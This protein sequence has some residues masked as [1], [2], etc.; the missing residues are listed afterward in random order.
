MSAPIRHP[1]CARALAALA[2]V[3]LAVVVALAALPARAR[4]ADSEPTMLM[5]DQQLI[6]DG[7]SHAI[8]VLHQLHSLG[9]DTVKV[10]LV[11]SLIAP[12]PNSRRA[13]HFDA[14]S[15]SAYPYGAWDRW[16]LIDNVA[17]QLGMS[18]SFQIIGPAPVWARGTSVANQGKTLGRFPNQVDLRQFVE[19]AG[20]RYSGSYVPNPSAA[21]ASGG[22]LVPVPIPTT[23]GASIAHVRQAAPYTGYTLPAGQA[24][25]RVSRWEIWNEPDE[26]DWLNPWFA[27]RGASTIYIEAGGY[28]RIVSAA[29]TGLH[30]TGHGSD[31]ILIGETANVGVRGPAYFTRALYCVGADDRPLRGDAAAALDCPAS[32][33][34]AQFVARNPGLFGATGFAHHPY[35]F[36]VPPDRPYTAWPGFITLQNLGTLERLLN[37]IF[38]S[39]GRA[40]S[41]GVP[42][43]VT[44]WGYDSDP[45]NP[46]NHTSLAEQAAW[47]DEGEFE[48]WQ[49]PWVRSDTQ[50]LLVDDA[51]KAGARRGSREYWS[52]FQTGLEFQ[53]GRRKPSYAAFMLP[54]WVPRARTGASVTV[55]GQLRPA[56]HAAMQYGVLQYQARGA[57]RFSTLA[58]VQTGSPEGFFVVR[59]R[60]PRP[61][62]IRLAWT[63][64]SG[65]TYYSR[66][67]AI[68]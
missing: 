63:S 26:A 67:V 62:Q 52:T 25:P 45:P 8:K 59:P 20:R 19:A 17:H 23:D 46:Y 65:V 39:Y 10:S 48:T 58:Q 42:I 38:A 30:D 34:A 55:W 12:D 47:I 16:D 29:W 13:P 41:G 27:R 7:S 1:V 36:N 14:T 68:N 33:D 32:G 66:T 37:G 64:P 49:M 60:I 35:G 6:Y 4:A 43:Y 50:F 51:P 61:G 18:V 15:P 2:L 21:T 44:E 28:R 56:D 9:V 22:G 57:S 24:L 31:T 11:W 54:I 53:N 3:A 5:D 40:R